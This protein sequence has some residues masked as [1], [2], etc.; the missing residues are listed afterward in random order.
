MK[1]LESFSAFMAF[2]FL[3]SIGLSNMSVEGAGVWGKT[4]KLSTLNKV[5]VKNHQGE[6]LGEIEDFIMDAQSGRIVLAV[7]SHAGVAGMGQK[8]KI[9]PFAFLSFDEPKKVFL[10]NI[11]KE[12]LTSAILVKNLKGVDLGKIEDLVI[13]AQGMIAFAILSH[14]KKS[15]IV[16]YAAL[17]MDQ[18]GGFFI[19]DVSEEK[20]ASVPPSG[21]DF[22][23]QNQAEKIYRYFG[24]RPYWTFDE[25]EK[26]A[27]PRA[28]PLQEF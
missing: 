14:K 8:V 18:A 2:L 26:P 1:K 16:P 27:L 3:T 19:L 23:S 25:A 9:I 15:V 5:E 12:D 13:N 20:L 17:S 22:I 21:E 11:R 24:L 6:K 7:L 10:L 4:Y 28:I